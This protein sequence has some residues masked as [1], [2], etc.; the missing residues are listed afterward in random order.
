VFQAHDYSIVKPLAAG[1]LVEVLADFSAP[2][3]PISLLVAPGK[4][5]S[6]KV[7]AFAE[8]IVGAVGQ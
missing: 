7:R 8:F 3:P 1:Q 5:V 6:P 2:G 4:R